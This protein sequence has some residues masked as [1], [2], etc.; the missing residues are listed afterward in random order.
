LVIF[1]GIIAV[2]PVYLELESNPLIINKGE[3]MK[4]AIIVLLAV[5]LAG[6]ATFDAKSL[7]LP[8]SGKAVDAVMANYSNPATQDLVT[9]T[10]FDQDGKPITS[11]S[12]AGPGILKSLTAG[13]TA[14]AVAAAV[15]PA[16][17][18][19][20]NIN[21][22]ATSSGAAGGAG[23][24]GGKGGAGGSAAAT[25]GNAVAKCGKAIAT[26]AQTQCQSQTSKSKGGWTPPGQDK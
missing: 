9:I 18:G 2:I 20:T 7:V 13:S 25:G 6:C 17:E 11:A 16:D 12:S 15:F 8:T 21:A 5:S 19:D 3:C 10:L 24:K 26:Q 14:G 22:P 4:K 23:G 1:H